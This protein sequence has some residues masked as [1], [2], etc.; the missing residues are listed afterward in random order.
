ML[1]GDE[2]NSRVLCPFSCEINVVAVHGAEHAP[3]FSRQLQLDGVILALSFKR[4][5]GDGVDAEAIELPCYLYIYMLVEIESKRILTQVTLP[6]PR[7]GMHSLLA[8]W[9]PSWQIAS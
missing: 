1:A 5:H 3:K 8:L 6:F 9:R 4:L 2:Y 7:R